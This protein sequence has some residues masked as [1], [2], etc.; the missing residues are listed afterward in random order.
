MAQVPLVEAG[1]P[2]SL[3]GVMIFN[4]PKLHARKIREIPQKYT[5]IICIFA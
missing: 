1:P 3:T 2:L 4:Q 5:L